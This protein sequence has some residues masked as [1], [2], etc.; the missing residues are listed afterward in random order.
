VG[1]RGIRRII[2]DE[3]RHPWRNILRCTRPSHGHRLLH[4]PSP[5][6]GVW[7]Y[8]VIRRPFQSSGTERV[9]ADAMFCVVDANV[10]IEAQQT[11]FA[12]QV[13][14]VRRTSFESGYR[15]DDDDIASVTLGHHLPQ[16]VFTGEKHA[17][18]IDGKCF[19]PDLGIDFVQRV[20]TVMQLNGGARHDD[21]ESP[22][23]LDGRRY[24]RLDLIFMSHVHRYIDGLVPATAQL[25]C[26]FGH[27]FCGQARQ[28][29]AGASIGHV[30]RTGGADTGSG[31][32]DECHLPLQSHGSASLTRAASY[33]CLRGMVNRIVPWNTDEPAS[34][35]LDKAQ[36]DDAWAELATHATKAFLVARRGQ[37]IYE[38]YGDGWAADKRHYTASMAKALVGGLSLAL[39]MD[40]GLVAPDDLAGKYV[41][42]WLDDPRKSKITL[43]D[44]AT[45]TSGIEDAELSAADRTQ[46]LAEGR[47]LT[48]HHMELPGWKGIFWRATNPEHTIDGEPDPFSISRDLAPVIFAPGTQAH[49]SNPGIAMLSYCLTVALQKSSASDIITLL[50]Q[51]I[52]E[53]LGLQEN[54]DYSI[55]YGRTWDVD[56]LPM[57]ANWGG[58]SFTPRATARVG[59]MLAQNGAWES[60]QLIAPNVLHTTL[61][62]AQKPPDLAARAAADPSPATGLGWWSNAD[63]YWQDIP[64]DAVLGAGAGDQILL[65]I[66][67]L[68]LVAVRNGGDLVSEGDRR[69]WQARL[70]YIVRPVVESLA[71]RSPVPSSPVITDIRWDPPGQVRRTVLGGHTRDGS[72]NWPLTWADDGQL[73]TAYGDGYGFEPQQTPDKLSL[74]FAVVTGGPD[75]FVGYNIRS[76]GERLGPGPKGEKASGLLCVDGVIYLWVRNADGEGNCGRLAWSEDHM[77]SWEWAD[78]KFAEFGHPSFVNFGRNYEGARDDYVY[79]ISHDHTSA[80]KQADRILLARMA[81]DAIR[82][83][84]DYEF[85][86]GTSVGT[87]VWSHDLSKVGAIFTHPG[88]CRR[89]S[90]SYV[91]G[92]GRYLLWQQLTIDGSDTR[93][94]S[95]FGLYDAPEPW[96]PWTTVF[97]TDRWDIGPG[98]LGHVNAKWTS[99]DGCT[100][101]LVFAG[102]DNFCAR[103]GR[104]TLS[105]LPAT[106]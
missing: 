55:G 101:W 31:A 76:D 8:V 82:E 75:D 27:S 50:R 5:C 104:L 66:P 47:T 52:F 18:K 36:L 23:S 30:Q 26:L 103:R 77:K 16:T 38:R 49:Y 90:M 59:Q 41:P 45:H 71:V 106:A 57:V 48:D 83:P 102:S 22:E 80:Y 100:I 15:G 93:F 3:K 79:V 24:G 46:A 10:P 1:T 20:V 84:E 25:L 51:R 9:T 91:P 4:T 68:D 43:R 81:K 12:S 7:V 32:G 67:S 11:V 95:G 13:R 53:P 28:C 42:Q 97:F 96:G 99:D 62:G 56:G 94:Q 78:W 37:L 60:R 34:V 73:Y 69:G 44:L 72:D 39:L 2:A 33:P 70:D 58:G 87:P 105:A 86:V 85:F 17:A 63:G 88:Q 29:D 61:T 19:V 89:S 35:G 92:L 6:L 98:D 40:D 64:N 65:V 74:G 14:D 54:E 21:I